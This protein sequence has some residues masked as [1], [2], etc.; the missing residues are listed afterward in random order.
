MA[1][2]LLLGLACSLAAGALAAG[3]LAAGGPSP[4]TVQGWEGVVAPGG[5]VR[6]V[7]MPAGRS[8][9]VAAVNVYGG[10]IVRFGS[11]AGSWGVPLVAYDGSA[12]GL[13]FDGGLLVLAEPS[14]G[15]FR[16][17]SRFAVLG[18][19]AFR[20]RRQIVLKGEF[21]F[22]ALSPD[23][24][25]LYVIEH[26]SEQDYSRYRVRAYDLRAGR[27]LAGA[28]AD[29]RSSETTMAGYPL[30]RA[31]SPDGRWVYTLYRNDG[32]DPFIHALDTRGRRAVCIDLPWKRSQDGLSRLRLS[33]GADEIVLRRRTG[34]VVAVVDART[35]EVRTV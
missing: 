11:L 20:V 17:V 4:G 27:L 33:A 6:Y 24:R 14:R 35:F 10:R 2:R 30:T 8:T 31:T 7:A 5:G 19:K 34:N 29:K 12:G 32:S 21:S 15:G 26:V 1:P 13:S 22:D 23:A 25:T 28:I 18:T 9:V 3:A 16:A